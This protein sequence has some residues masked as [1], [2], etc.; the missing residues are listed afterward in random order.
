MGLDFRLTMLVLDMLLRIGV[1]TGS[2]R[3]QSLYGEHELE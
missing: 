3:V 2:G 1:A